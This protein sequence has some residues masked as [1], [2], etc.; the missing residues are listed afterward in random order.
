MIFSFYSLVKRKIRKMFEKVE[1]DGGSWYIDW[2]F[3]MCF[4]FF[5][6]GRVEGL[7]YDF[8]IL[9]VRSFGLL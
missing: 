3:L 9:V 2:M 7:L 8:S 5:R 1:G 6:R 4:F